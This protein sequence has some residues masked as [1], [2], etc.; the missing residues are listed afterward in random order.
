MNTLSPDRARDCDAYLFGPFEVLTSSG[1]LLFRGQR[2]KIQDL[3]FR[4]LVVLLESPGR[5]VSREDLRNQLW[6]DRIF[7]EFDTN[8]RVAAAKLRDALGDSAADPQYFETVSGHGYR[9]IAEVATRTESAPPM[10]SDLV[11][12]EAMSDCVVNEE[13]EALQTR[14][15]AKRLILTCV[16]L[17]AV[18]LSAVLLVHYARH[19][20]TD[21]QDKVVVGGF[22][23]HSNDP[24]LEGVFSIP[25]RV[26][27]EESPYLNFIPHR[28]FRSVV[29]NADSAALDSQLQ[30]CVSLNAQVLLQGELTSKGKGYGVAVTAYRCADGHRVAAETADAQSRG[31]LLPALDVAIEH[32]RHRLGESEKSVQQFNTPLAQATSGSLAALKAF[33]LGV[34][35]ERNGQATEAMSEYKLA[36]ALDPQFAFAYELLGTNYSNAGELSAA[37]DCFHKAFELRERTT[38]RERLNITA[39]YYAYFT[40]EIERAIEAYQLWSSV[41]PRD[42]APLNNLANQY[43]LLGE[44]EKSVVLMRKAIQIDPSFDRLYATLAQVYLGSGDYSDLNLIC[45]DRVHGRT[46][47]AVLHLDCYESAFAQNDAAGMERQMEWARGNPEENA[48]LSSEAEAMLYRGNLRQAKALFTEATKNALQYNLREAAATVEVWQALLEAEMGAK[49]GIKEVVGDAVSLVPDSPR[50]RA[51][52]ALVLARIGD[53]QGAQTEASKVH[54]QSPQNTLLN[55]G[56]LAASQAV[57]RLS[58]QDPEGAVQA[59]EPARPY[60]FNPLMGFATSYYRGLAYLEGKHWKEATREFQRTLDHRAAAPLSAFVPLSQL[61]LGRSY[62]LAGDYANA[63]LAYAQLRKIWEKADPSFPPLRRLNR[64]QHE[65][66]AMEREA[67]K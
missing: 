11:P 21:D 24:A 66:E 51:L 56:P 43:R 15:T 67:K 13:P 47:S 46:D 62:Q 35:K 61:Q 44:S 31:A 52:A 3:P 23:N 53:A 26:K 54:E 25:F 8:L 33:A 36:I 12:T 7:V 39:T 38:D 22:V 9:F 50:I 55:F 14:F 37:R 5:V 10:P 4:M 65:L 60:D 17:L 2:V 30:A 59:L 41:Y 34:E 64:Y 42:I 18:L 29:K 57:L 27:L 16:L 1:I 45:N 28:E 32:M 20:L 48:F 63:Q 58:Q 40:G 49:P 19:P 6:G